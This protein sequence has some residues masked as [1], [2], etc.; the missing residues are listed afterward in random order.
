MCS[1]FTHQ[2]TISLL[3]FNFAN[4][5]AAHIRRITRI[6]ATLLNVLVSCYYVSGNDNTFRSIDTCKLLSKGYNNNKKHYISSLMDEL[7]LELVGGTYGN[8]IYRVTE[9]G[10]YV[11]RL[12]DKYYRLYMKEMK[13]IDKK[14]RLK[15]DKI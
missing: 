3:E 6:N 8:Y 9:R 12:Y 14:V 2:K 4:K 5:L 11:V 13:E 10:L 7:C 1:K 15:R